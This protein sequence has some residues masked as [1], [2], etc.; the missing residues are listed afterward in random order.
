MRVSVIVPVLNE[1]AAI[2]PLV[3]ALFAQDPEPDE[4]VI[5]DGGSDDGTR[6]MLAQLAELHPRLKI[7]DGPGGIAG[8]R[9]AA[10][11]AATGE[12]IACT[13]AGCLPEPGW[14]G[15]L[16][17]PFDS[18]ADWVAGFYRPVGKS[19]ASTAAGVVMMT[20]LEEVDLDHFLPGGS[21]QAFT[22]KAWEKV[23][24]FPE[25]TS[26]GEDT[27]F[28]ER[29]RSAGY[30]PKFAPDALVSWH[31]PSSLNEMAAKARVW[32]K[33]DGIN[34]VRTGAYLRIIAAYWVLPL[35][36]LG[37]ALWRWL[38]G[39]ALLTG[40]FGIVVY[41]TRFKF[42]WVPGPGKWLLVPVAHVRQQLAQSQGWL[43]GFGVQNLLRKIAVRALRPVRRVLPAS[44]SAALAEDR[45]AVRHNVD[46]IVE[47]SQVCRWLEDTPDTYR[48]GQVG[49][50]P[51]IS[52]VQAT[53]EL[54][55]GSEPVIAPVAVSMAEALTAELG[56]EIPDDPAAAYA[57]LRQSGH[58]YYL[59]PSP[60]GRAARTDRITG[61][62]ALVI[63]AAVPLHDVGGGSRA[64]QIAQEGASRG[65]HVM[66]VSRFDAAESVDLG[67]RF[68]HAALEETTLDEF[69]VE[70]YV[71]R[72]PSGPRLVLVEF[73]HRDYRA[74][75]ELLQ[76]HGFKVIY[77]LIDDWSDETL[78]GGWYDRGFVQWL[79][80]RANVLTASAPSL[81]QALRQMTDREVLEIANG[82]NSRVFRRQSTYPVPHDLP[83]GDGPV[84]EYHG[85]LYGDWFDW[86]ALVRV[87]VAFPDARILLIGDRSQRMP[88][89]P[90]NVH[91][92]GLKA[93]SDLA[94]Y[95]DNTSVG[96]IPFVVSRTTHAVS[97]L[98]VFEYLAMGVPVA[99]TPLQPLEGLEGVYTDAD[100]VV[101]VRHALEGPPPDG[102]AALARHGWGERLGSLLGAAGVTLPPPTSPVRVTVRP[103][104]H[105]RND[106][107]KLG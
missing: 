75:I 104:T 59:L 68:I 58:P 40:F 52:V 81:V 5:A 105:Y 29:L 86:Q 69:D 91:A 95:L 4:V 28:G 50:R 77:D 97:P 98:K 3:E 14:L 25:G 7:V 67:L 51:G 6:E 78:G 102:E 36:A 30:R 101:A 35:F 15:A 9:N 66:Y 12:I 45:R 33:A 19:T 46:V 64:A 80:G 89:I 82:V 74:S 18:G 79:L 17:R 63:L 49:I 48:V 56:T 73:P 21:S 23:G 88:T 11:R 53:A 42:A 31:P 65:I 43:G 1:R 83:A 38:A 41:R 92:L 10:I 2:G 76:A 37:V 96:L 26:A 85:S 103:I 55:S 32:G 93:Q 71:K 72:D 90:D 100:L 44:L 22:Q 24:G 62:A 99:A 54:R 39:L 70:A 61:P 34:R 13:D 8:N 106:E 87:A 16:A 47:V 20:V 60:G 27:L 57:L 94:A 84:F 107:R